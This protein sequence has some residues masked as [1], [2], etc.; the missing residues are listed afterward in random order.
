MPGIRVN[1]RAFVSRAPQP[2]TLR[3]Q[4]PGGTS[5]R[6]AA[7]LRYDITLTTRYEDLKDV[8]KDYNILYRVV[9]LGLMTT[10]SLICRFEFYLLPEILISLWLT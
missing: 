10:F 8:D 9:F 4:R 2:H 1:G 3:P 6:V 5:Y 7:L